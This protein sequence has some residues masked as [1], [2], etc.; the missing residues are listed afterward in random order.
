[1]R[2]MTYLCAF[3]AISHTQGVTMHSHNTCYRFLSF[4]F[5]IR[6]WSL[7]WLSFLTPSSIKER[8]IVQY[9]PTRCCIA[10]SLCLEGLNP[11]PTREDV[12]AK[13]DGEG[14]GC[15]F[16]PVRVLGHPGQVLDEIVEHVVVCGG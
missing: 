10:V 13:Y 5:H 16:V 12:G 3:Q 1:M 9:Q 11:R 8:P 15:H 7:R 6:L 14:D 2:I 4:V